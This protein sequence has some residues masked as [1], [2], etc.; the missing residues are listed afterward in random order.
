MRCCEV[1]A[2]ADGGD[3][4]GQEISSWKSKVNGESDRINV[5][6]KR[7]AKRLRRA[8]NLVTRKAIGQSSEML[9]CV[10][11]VKHYAHKFAASCASLL[12]NTNS[13]VR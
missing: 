5:L 8:K 6:M 9:R 11:T 3:L 1:S 2:Q 7:I 10:V 13:Q 4:E 12:Y